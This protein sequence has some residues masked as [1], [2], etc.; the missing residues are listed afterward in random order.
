MSTS[1]LNTSMGISMSFMPAL[2]LQGYVPLIQS[3]IQFCVNSPR[4]I[5]DY[6]GLID[7][8]SRVLRPGGLIYLA[9]FD[10]NVYD[11]N[12]QLR[13]RDPNSSEYHAWPCWVES[14][15]SAIRS[16]GG[17]VDV[18]SSLPR[19]VEEH[20]AFES[21]V[22]QEHWIPTSPWMQGD[23]PE[24]VRQRWI[25][26]LAR[27]D[28]LVYF[29]SLNLVKC[30]MFHCPGLDEVLSTHATRWWDVGSPYKRNGEKRNSRIDRS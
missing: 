15:S 17:G 5:K 22:C 27:D 11:P 6:P 1:G 19:W 20:G 3:L 24:A 28:V 2:S 7:H 13:V 26:E 16:R 12:K 29:S 8:I 23:D 25:G 21:P 4:Q 10:F 9:E 18:A 30:F 14:I